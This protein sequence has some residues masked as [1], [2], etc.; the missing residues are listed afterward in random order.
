MRYP[1]GGGLSARGR[2]GREL[3]RLQAAA[4]FAEGIEPPEVARRLRISPNSAYV[5]R[6]HS[7]DAIKRARAFCTE[8]HGLRSFAVYKNGR[9]DHW[10][11][12]M[13]TANLKTPIR[14]RKADEK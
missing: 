12:T 5:W 7:S 3:V 4:W 2:I 11:V 9:T 13:N 14:G 8:H 10:I 6:R 1:D